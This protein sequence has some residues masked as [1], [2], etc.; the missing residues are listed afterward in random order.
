[1]TYMKKNLPLFFLLCGLF[2]LRHMPVQAQRVS[3][4]TLWSIG[5]A[6][7]SDTDFALAPSGYQDFL[8]G[9]FGWEDGYYLIGRSNPKKDWPYALPGPDDKWGG[10]TGSAGWHA[11]HLNIL[12]GIDSLP[13]NPTCRLVIY[14]LDMSAKN[15]PLVK[16][17]INDTSW[18]YQLPKGS[19]DTSLKGAAGPFHGDVLD[20]PVP[21]RLLRKGGNEISL[22]NLRGSWLIFDQVR[23]QG[24]DDIVISRPGDAFIRNITPAHYEIEN[25][26]RRAQPLLIDVQTPPLTLDSTEDSS[27]AV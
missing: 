3:Q 2:L 11:S 5:N 6:D 20:I 19:G 24:P 10:T 13:G 8:K 15:P 25:G 1:M 27:D 26:G 18:E 21:G 17:S 4:T 12:F 23:M 22:I 9:D 7:Q 14:L 16:V